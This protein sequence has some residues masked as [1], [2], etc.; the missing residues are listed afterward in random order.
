M[1]KERI[2]SLKYDTIDELLNDKRY[3]MCIVLFPAHEK[4]REGL[5]DGPVCAYISAGI[6]VEP[7]KSTNYNLAGS[8]SQLWEQP[9]PQVQCWE[10]HGTQ[11]GY[12]KLW[13][14]KAKVLNAF[15]GG[16]DVFAALPHRLR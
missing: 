11:L 12:Q 7:I 1:H 9:S 6:C 4:Q 3:G 10:R 5:G 2:Q 8:Q 16:R 13:K 15:F 14:D